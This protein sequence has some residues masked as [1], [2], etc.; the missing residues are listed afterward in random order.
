VVTLLGSVALVGWAARSALLVQ[1]AP[2]LAPMQANRAACFALTGIA[3]LGIAMSR[4]RLT[5]ISSAITAALA[6]V[7][8]L[9]YLFHA[10]F[11]IGEIPDP[12]RIAPAAA[13]CFIVLAAGILLSQPSLL[14]DRSPLLGI[15]GLVIAAVGAA[16]CISV[17]S[18]SENALASSNLTRAAFPTGVGFLLLGSHL[19]FRQQDR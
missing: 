16:G 6:A 10:N 3:L 12:D 7:T 2:Y 4:R 14:T 9:G 8:L 17:L 5:L 1:V 13:L 18:G 15:T 11:R 19:D